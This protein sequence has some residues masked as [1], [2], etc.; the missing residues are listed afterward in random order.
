[1]LICRKCNTAL[2][3]NTFEMHFRRAH[4]LTGD[5][6]REINDHY[7]G[8]DLADPEHDTLP[9]DGSAAIELL[10][11]LRGHSCTACRHLTVA[12]DNA[13]RHWREAQHGKAE[14]RWTDVL[15]QTWMRGKYAR[16]W[17]VRGRGND[18]DE[19]A[20]I[21]ASDNAGISA[22]ERMIASSQAQLKAEDAIR[23]RMGDLEEDIDRDSSWIKR[24]G[25]VR[26]FGSRD[27]V[28]VHEAAEWVRAKAATGGRARQEDEEAGRERL[29][30]A[31]LGQSFDREVDR[32]CWRLDSV[33]TETLQWLASI[34]AANPSG[35]PF[36]R[37]GKEASMSKYRSVGHRYLSFCWRAY[38]IGR[39]EAFE[40]WAVRFTD[41]QWSLLRDVAEELEG[42]IFPSSHDSGFCSGRERD[43]E[44]DD[45]ASSDDDDEEEVTADEGIVT[46]TYGALDRAVFLFIVASI[47][48]HVGG[49]V[50]TNSLLSFCAAL[51]V[52]QRPLGYTEPHLYTG[53]LAAVLWWGRLFFLESVFENQPRD[54]DEVG[55]DAVLAF[56]EQHTT[57]MC[58]GTHT[59]I[60]TIIGWM[61]YGKGW[62]NKMGGQASIRWTENGE[63][64]VHMGE[65]VDVESFTRTLRG[66]V[67]EAQKLLDKLFGGLWQKVSRTVDLSR[68]ADNMVRLGAGQSFAANPKNDWL[69]AGP[70][71]IMGLMEAS[72]WDATRNRWKKQGVKKW[73]RRLRQFRETLMVLVHTWGGLPGR[74]PELTTLRHCDSWQLI[75]NIF[76][77][78]G[79]VM[80]V[81]DRD[82]M[83]A[84]RDN[85]RKVARFVPDGIGRMIVAYISWLIPAERVLRRECKLAEPRGEQLEYMWRDGSSRVWDT[86]RLSRKLARVMQAG[87]GVRIGVG[88]YRAVA[89][90]MGRRIRGLVTKQLEGRM[91]DEDNDDNIEVDPITGEP[92]DCGGSWNIVWDLQSTHGTR[93]ARQHYA[94]HIGFPGKLQ[95]EMIATFKEISK[96]WHQFLESRIA[97]DKAPT[98]RKRNGRVSNKQSVVDEDDSPAQTTGRKRVRTDKGAG[99][100][101]MEKDMADGLQILFGPDAVWRSDKQVESMRSIMSL[102]NGQTAINV[103]PTGAGK[104]IL[105]MLPAVMR[106]TG[107][108]IVVVPFVA[109]MDDLV[110]RATDMGI[111][112]IRFRSSMNSGREGVPRAARLVVVSADIVSSAEFSGYVDGLLCAGLLQR[113]FIDECH[114]VIMDIG[115]RAKL[116]ELRSLHRYGCPIVLLTAT[117]PVVLEDWFRGE[118]LAQSAVIVRDRTTK[119]N[120]RYRVEQVK[121]GAG[122]VEKRTVE[123]IEQL[124]AQ[125]T[126]HQ[127]GVIYCRSRGQC[128]AMAEAIGCGVHHSGMTEKD[129][130]EARMAWIEGRAS[131]WI[132]ATTGLGTGVDIAGIVAVVHVE[133]PYG[134]VDFVQQ[135]GRGG[136]R[137]GEVV[138]SIIIHDGRPQREDRHGS[139]VDN[140]NRAQMD[141]FVSTPGC[142]RAVIAAFMDG[143]AGETCR[144]VAGAE[145]CDGCKA[146]A[147]GKVD[148][149]SEGGAD[150]DN[151]EDEGEERGSVWKVFGKREGIQIRTLFRWLDE[152]ADECPVCHV[153][154]HYRGQETGEVPDEP[155]HRRVGQWCETVADED[156]EVVRKKI[157]FGPLSCCFTCKLPLDWCAETQEEEGHC[158]YK[159]KV[160]PVVLMGLRNWRVR[161]LAK[162]QFGIDTQDKD[163]F[164][165]WLG[166]RRQ[167]HGEGGTNMHA[168]WE[169]IIWEAYRGGMYWFKTE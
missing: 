46:P 86:E 41:E 17:T 96:L 160:L 31:R 140:I 123:V 87:T 71:K 58:T 54:Q 3:P 70:A 136:R 68:I 100:R 59:V 77:M 63:A 137:A 131:R 128:E 18:D 127:K 97:E 45:E 151:E 94:V 10:P 129:R 92:I 98:T 113:I 85:G 83:K 9:A 130:Y 116:G 108:S 36:G 112:C 81:T 64:V 32:C 148:R 27:L 110:T 29:L 144:D 159:D 122:A 15:L 13:V 119:L 142:R 38:R 95:P 154:R 55:I 168:L 149:E 40:R 117:L 24:L 30:L 16:Y 72:I 162:E 49:N 104:S 8:M 138:K 7:T 125:L 61:A 99:R 33:P 101:V 79:Q 155:R 23:L 35:V 52:Q 145:L 156:Y 135:T 90:E 73:L 53:M 69:K 6:L 14:V 48:V 89:I 50:Y 132:V 78:D 43:A 126:G 21:V 139:F 4:Q 22:M 67:A 39:E 76:V 75:R 169:A 163:A 143:V 47:K 91:E 57:W 82:K 161:D 105:F 118:M 25:W 133:Q 111:D 164:F 42:D 80:I 51:G 11:V 106:E 34:T 146:Q 2:R 88:R 37:K 141:A 150:E 19:D 134:L 166:A 93:I 114:T 5:T 152:V 62:R 44:S 60:S 109:L 102:K 165:R 66:Q 167:F 153:R 26:H 103:L 74:G 115:Y 124:D 120:C 12:R 1:M 20:G 157:T 84:I 121:P 158:A 147:E 107:T 56:R 65:Q 28:S